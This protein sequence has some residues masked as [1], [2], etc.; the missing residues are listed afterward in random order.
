MNAS[1]AAQIRLQVALSALQDLL[2]ATRDEAMEEQLDMDPA[3]ER[4]SIAIQ[5]LLGA[6]IDVPPRLMRDWASNQMKRDANKVLNPPRK[7]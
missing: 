1:Y 7:D 2:H 3:R 4:A 6:P 5:I